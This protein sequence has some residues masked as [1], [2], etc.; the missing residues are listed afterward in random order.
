MA[1]SQT[2]LKPIKTILV[3]Q[4]E[5][6]NPKN[7]YSDIV[8]KFK[9]KMDFRKFISVEEVSAKDFRKQRVNILDYTAV[10]FN[11]RNAI[12]HF[13]RICEELRVKMPESTKYFCI[14]DA[15]AVYLQKYIQFR[16]RKVFSSAT[17]KEKG[18]L[19]L[20]GKHESK[21]KFLF[22][23]AAN[24][25]D[26]IC[27]FLEEKK[28]TYAEAIIYEAKN[29]DLSDLKGKVHHDMIIFFTPKG[30]ES[31]FEN[32]P[33]FKQGDTRICGMGKATQKA[34][35]DS[36]LRIDLSAPTKEAPSIF[37]A[38]EKYLEDSNKRRRK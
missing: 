6:E 28:A 14:T 35:I 29:A 36:G 10:I 19:D 38:I 13:F 15:I 33:D 5:P 2:E 1:K 16:K 12:D 25:I 31:L 3:S 34:I 21:E 26:G 22:P 24:H 32:F 17:G 27:D 9:V 11:S 18:L 23:C 30:V 7:P 20:L 8:A 37:M 4:P